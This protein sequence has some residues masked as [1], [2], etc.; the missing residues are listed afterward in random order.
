MDGGDFLP[1]Q[2]N[3]AQSSFLNFVAA[4]RIVRGCTMRTAAAV[5]SRGGKPKAAKPKQIR[6]LVADDHVLIL[7]GLTATIGRQEDMSVVAKAA[8]GREAVYLWKKHRP[9]VTLLDL[10]MPKLNGVA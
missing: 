4:R 3:V 1:T 2:P 9:D 6:L 10:R 7:E 8:D 5:L